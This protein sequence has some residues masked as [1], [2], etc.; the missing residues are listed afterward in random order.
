MYYKLTGFDKT[1]GQMLRIDWYWDF[2]LLE[3]RYVRKYEMPKECIP[4][5]K[6]YYLFFK[7]FP[8]EDGWWL[9]DNL[10]PQLLKYCVFDQK[11]N[12]LPEYISQR[13]DEVNKAI[14]KFKNLCDPESI[15]DRVI[16]G[17]DRKQYPDRI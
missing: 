10:P 3:R 16:T 11:V 5:S 4:G 13:R 7:M 12:R 9:E 17:L 2:A 6:E 14:K 8:D 1:N 15:T